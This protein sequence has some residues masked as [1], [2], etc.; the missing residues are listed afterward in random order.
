[1]NIKEARQK[2]DLHSG[3]NGLSAYPCPCNIKGHS[4]RDCWEAIGFLKGVQSEE[5]KELVK[6]LQEILQVISFENA[7]HPLDSNR[8]NA[9]IYAKESLAKYRETLEK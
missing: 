9:E 8:V 6:A 3:L 1:M 2:S 7:T 5:V 4:T